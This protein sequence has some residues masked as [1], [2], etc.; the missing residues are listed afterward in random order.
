MTLAWHIEGAGTNLC[1]VDLLR[2][3]EVAVKICQDINVLGMIRQ[4][5][6]K[7]VSPARLGAHG[8][9]SRNSRLV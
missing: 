7:T 2:R 3:V 4:D 1:G 5:P 9:S 8:T 6:T